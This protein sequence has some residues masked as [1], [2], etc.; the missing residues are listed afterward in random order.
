MNEIGV[1]P[2]VDHVYAM[3]VIDEV[4]E[5]GGKVLSFVSYCGG[6]PAQRRR[7]TPLGTSLVGVHVVCCWLFETRPSLSVVVRLSL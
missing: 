3:K 1:D 7:I 5:K 4:H 2:G 6:L